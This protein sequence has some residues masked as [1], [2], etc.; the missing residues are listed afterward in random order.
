MRDAQVFVEGDASANADRSTWTKMAIL[1][2][3]PLGVPFHIGWRTDQFTAAEFYSEPAE[4]LDGKLGMLVGDKG[5]WFVARPVDG[6]TQLTID[7]VGSSH[8]DYSKYRDIPHY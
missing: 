2:V 8:K 3:H 5:V 4:T 1:E 7:R 6:R